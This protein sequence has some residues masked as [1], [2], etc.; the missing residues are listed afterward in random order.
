MALR[1][2]TWN[3]N[4]VRARLE[5]VVAWLGKQQPDLVCLQELKCQDAQFPRAELEA[6]G[7]QAQV[8]GQKTYNGVAI[9]SKGEVTDVRRNLDDGDAM[10]RVISG[11]Y[12][13]VRVVGVY[14]PNGQ[15]V[16]SEAY[17]YKLAW[18]AR[19][20][21][22]LAA[23]RGPEPVLLCGDFN[24]APGPLDVWDVAAMEGQTLFTQKEKDALAALMARHGLHDSFREKHPAE[25]RFSWWD[26][27]M[28]AFPKNQG[29][30]ID[31]VLVQEP[32]WQR[33]TG[34]VIDRDE[35]K[36]KQASDHAPVIIELAD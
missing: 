14:A 1:I 23:T 13:G 10:A 5:R 4:S 18:Y 6:L 29:L 31:H 15:E 35:R 28:L 19:L 36:G 2:A 8:F 26:Y 16:D 7:Y 21:E 3:V 34:V 33:C 9:L 22:W 24:I 25:Q 12:R 27:R 30:R 20:T 11:V 32:L 17:V